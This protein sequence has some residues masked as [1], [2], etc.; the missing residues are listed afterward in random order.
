MRYLPGLLLLVV[1]SFALCAQQLD[2]GFEGRQSRDATY[3]T[4]FAGGEGFAALPDAAVKHGGRQ[5]M[6]LFAVPFR[7]DHLGAW[8]AVIRRVPAALVAGHRLTFSAWVRTDSLLPVGAALFCESSKVHWETLD[9]AQ[10]DTVRGITGWQRL[11]L[12]TRISSQ[13]LD[14]LVGCRT[15]G[16]GRAWVDDVRLAIDGRPFD[17]ATLPPPAVP[18]GPE[19]AWLRGAAHPLRT[20]DPAAP[21]TTDLVAFGRLLGPARVIALGEAS[22]GT[23]EAMATKA[24]LIRYLVAHHRLEAVVLEAS[25]PDAEYLNRYV[26][27][28]EGTALDGLRRVRFWSLGNQDVLDLVEWLRGYNQTAARPV[29]VVGCDMQDLEGAMSQLRDITQRYEPAYAP[30]L[31]RGLAT[32]IRF[33]AVYNEEFYGTYAKTPA[34]TDSSM[35]LSRT[36]LAHYAALATAR[37]EAAVAVRSARVINQLC[38]LLTAKEKHGM[39]DQFMAENTGYLLESVGPTA[40]AVV[41]AH[42]GHLMRDTSYVTLGS[43]LSR[44]FGSRFLSVGFSFGEGSLISYFEFGPTAFR[45]W[46]PMEGS[47][48]TWFGA[49]GLPGFYLDL[50]PLRSR[51]PP[52]AARWLTRPRYGRESSSVGVTES[53]S[54]P[55]DYCRDFDVL[56][57]NQHVTPTVIV[58]RR[59]K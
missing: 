26:L 41:W 23:H 28:G 9:N 53:N 42:N 36:W 43:A 18:T 6:R 37:P 10:S 1:N 44:R 13:A 15:G 32:L 12:T 55:Y 8:G 27:T 57:Y 34:L 50:R 21:D 56:I 17:P 22:H 25:L 19:L 3:R 30:E 39:R 33:N 38:R 7:H 52:T 14:V 46:P 45:A 4:W 48:E 5:S 40:R 51:T 16:W 2:M 31:A 58:N 35:A 47:Y 11:T 20:T 49:A 59:P 54:S 24:R 29:Q